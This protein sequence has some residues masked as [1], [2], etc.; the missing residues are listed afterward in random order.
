MMWQNGAHTHGEAFYMRT[1]NTHSQYY[2]L[3]C[4]HSPVKDTIN[5]FLEEN[6]QKGLNQSPQVTLHL[7]EAVLAPCPQFSSDGL[8]LTSFNF[9]TQSLTWDQGICSFWHHKEW[10][11]QCITA[12]WA[13]ISKG[14]GHL[15]SFHSELWTLNS[16]VKGGI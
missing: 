3:C 16:Q 15:K 9:P 13:C 5:I 11:D 6:Q 14:L 1:T 7:K 10:K 2:R 8:T 12:A 4:T